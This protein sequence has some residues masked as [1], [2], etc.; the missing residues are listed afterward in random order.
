[1]PNE[2]ST[3]AAPLAPSCAPL[4]SLLLPE[5]TGVDA[6]VVDVVVVLGALLLV[7]VEAAAAVV[8]PVVPLLALPLALVLD[9]FEPP[10]TSPSWLSAEKMLSMNPIMPPPRSPPPLSSSRWCTR[11]SSPSPLAELGVLA[12]VPPALWVKYGFEYPVTPEIVMID[13]PNGL[14]KPRPSTQGRGALLGEIAQAP[15]RRSSGSSY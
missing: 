1:V 4:A 14:G 13:I 8:L 9:A 5:A 3:L 11:P 15:A 10:G 2:L 7:V 6:V 12:C